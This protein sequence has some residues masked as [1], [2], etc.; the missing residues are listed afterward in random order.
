MVGGNRKENISFCVILFFFCRNMAVWTS[1]VPFCL[2]WEFIICS[3]RA[4]EANINL[5][6]SHYALDV[7]MFEVHALMWLG[8]ES[9]MMQ[10]R[11]VGG[12]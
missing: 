11:S 5:N 1:C 8:R 4:N 2:L 3:T 12:G 7:S 10:R 6:V 9:G